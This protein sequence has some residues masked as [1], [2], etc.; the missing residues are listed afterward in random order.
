MHLTLKDVVNEATASDVALY[1]I[2]GG[3][4]GNATGG[5]EYGGL[6]DIS[7]LESYL[8]A[9][10]TETA[11]RNLA[12][13]TGG[14]VVGR[15]SNFD[16]AFNAVAQDISDYYSLGFKPRDTKGQKHIVVKMKNGRYSPRARS[17]YTPK[18]FETE[19][20]ERVVANL[21]HGGV[22]SE[23]PITVTMGTAQRDGRYF[24]V[25]LEIALAPTLAL[26]P[27]G[28]ELTGAYTVYVMMGNEGGAVSK[29]MK[30]AHPIRIPVSAEAELRKQPL[31]Y[32]ATLVMRPGE[33]TL[34]VAV[35]DQ[36]TNVAGYAT[37][38]IT[39]RDAVQ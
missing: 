13:L 10:N 37:A 33:N 34:S 35:V 19:V 22:K 28:R 2:D 11:F 4:S 12:L 20:A 27:D 30:S 16:R 38:T 18:T 17:S 23:W 8:A 1:F 3:D 29:L 32:A 36:L 15:S 7:G 24:R 14:V 6:I 26:V 21:F 39:P 9:N 31:T 5:V 25:P